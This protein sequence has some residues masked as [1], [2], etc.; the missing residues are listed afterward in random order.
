MYS[1]FVHHPIAF[2]AFCTNKEF[3][4]PDYP[5]HSKHGYIDKKYQPELERLADELEEANP[6]VTVAMGNTAMWAL[7]GKT[8]I[9]KLRGTVQ[10]STHTLTGLK[11][12]P[13]YHPAAIFRQYSLRPIVVLDLRKARRESELPRHS[14]TRTSHMD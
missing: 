11:V 6:N 10:L 1:I 13:T 5:A 2:E 3:G 4:I 14:L 7:L 9:S 12:L 8:S